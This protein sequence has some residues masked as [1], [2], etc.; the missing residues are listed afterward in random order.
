MNSESSFIK[1][2]GEFSSRISSHFNKFLT[3]PDV[4]RRILASSKSSGVRLAASCTEDLSGVERGVTIAAP[5]FLRGG[6]RL[7]LR[8]LPPEQDCEF[9]K[10]DNRKEEDDV[11]HGPPV[12][13]DDR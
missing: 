6:L 2:L 1:T 7:S 12:G 10:S 5:P 8:V 9:E 3:L 4:F 11:E 13:R